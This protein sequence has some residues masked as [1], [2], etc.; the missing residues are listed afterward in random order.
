MRNVVIVTM[1]CSTVLTSSIGYAKTLEDILKEKGVITEDDYKSVTANK[2][3]NYRIGDGFTFLSNDEKFKMSLGASM[4]LRYTL[5]NLDGTNNTP[6]KQVQDSSK[7]ELR[8]VKLFLNGNAYS[9]DL[10]YKLQLNFTNN[11]GGTTSN[12][13]LMEEVWLNYRLLDE[14]QFRVGQDKVQFGRQFI[15]SSTALQFVDLSMVSNAFVPGYD[16]GI[17]LHGKIAG[18]LVN[19]NIAGYGGLGQNTFRA[20]TDNA[21]STRVTINPLGEMKYSES[22]MEFSNKPL[23]SFGANFYRNTLNPSEQNTATATNNQLSFNASKKG[24]FALGNPLFDTSRQINLSESVDYNTAGFDTAFKFRGLSMTGEYFIGQ[25][26]GNTTGNTVRAQG[27]YAQL[28]YFVVPRC[29]ELAARYSYLDPN[30]DVAN[31]LWVETTGAVS[32]YINDHNL[33]LQADYTNVHKQKALT[34]NNGP[35][36]TDD[37]QVRIQAQLLF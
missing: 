18:G 7:F 21:F 36:A 28:G 6:T 37:Q 27:F 15:T 2:P 20:T 17:M 19:Y 10:T 23:V 14:L 33:K 5:M 16:T 32:W 13:G 30:R 29:L 31:D 8:R 34:F 4:Q 12:G 26:D 9:K 24:W 11:T 35:N 22:D 1:V 25:A 3:L